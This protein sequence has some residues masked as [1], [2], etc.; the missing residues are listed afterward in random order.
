MSSHVVLLAH[1]LRSGELALETHVEDVCDRIEALEPQ[2]MA[3]LPEP[4]RRARLRREA[5][6]LT[7]RFPEPTQRPPLFGVLVGVK[8]IFRVDGW[9]T[10]AGSS[11]PAE[12]F[13]GTEAPSVAA[14]RAAGALVVGKTVTTEFAYFAPGPTRN[15]NNLG[16]TPGG[17]SSGSAAAVAAGFC[18]LALGTQTI[19]SVIRP[20][21]Y[22]GVAGFKPTYGR[23]PV[24]GV[25]PSAPSLDTVG[26]FALDVAGIALAAAVVCSSWTARDAAAKPVLGVPEGAYLGQASSEARAAF[27]QQIERLEAAGFTVRRVPALA[28]IA[29]IAERHVRLVEGEMAAIHHEWF[30]R[31][32]ELY[33]PE[34]SA[35]IR[36]GQLVQPD[37]IEQARAGRTAL[38]HE[39]AEQMRASAI[40]VWICPAAIGPA[41][42]GLAT[43]GSP[44]MNLP[45]TYAGMPA[46]T[47]PAGLAASGLPLGLQCVGAVGADEQLLAWAEHVAVV[48]G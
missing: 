9:A 22:C 3:L 21:A 15:P 48:V 28:R 8:D 25:I 43:T 5:A 16:H 12:L 37:E 47:V 11:L 44:A 29:E 19:G 2:I 26:L 6:A 34:T 17:S 39:L 42:A 27:E 40:D 35:A 32:A 41:P 45:W 1:A 30:G 38:R 7:R 23:I 24:D 4:D 20:A 36:R 13:G 33:R 31:Y 10:R 46:V 14:L 18:S